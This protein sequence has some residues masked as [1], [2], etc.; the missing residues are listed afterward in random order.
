MYDTEALNS[1]RKSGLIIA[2]IRKEI[3]ADITR[4]KLNDGRVVKAAADN[5]ATGGAG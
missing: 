4:R 1:F 2:K 3:L 5:R